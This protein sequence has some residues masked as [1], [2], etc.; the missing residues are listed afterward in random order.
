MK[1]KLFRFLPFV[2]AAFTLSSCDLDDDSGTYYPPNPNIAFGIIANASPDSGDL[3]FYADSNQINN[4]ALNYPGAAGYYN[5]YLG[6]RTFKLEDALGN[7]LATTQLTLE[8]GDYF[9]L[10][11]VNTFSNIELIA[12]TDALEYPASGNSRIRFI[13]LTVDAPF[14]TI[15]NGTEPLANDLE[16]KDATEFIEIES[17]VYNLTYSDTNGDELFVQAAEFKPGRI[18]TIYT[19]GYVTPPTGSN[20]TFSTKTILNY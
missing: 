15:A 7:E 19:K 6:N 17:G 14:V 3:Y 20:D 8:Q 10:F 9:S 18:Y 13:N 5:F 4:A 1:L 12:Y 16:F 11:A 2:L